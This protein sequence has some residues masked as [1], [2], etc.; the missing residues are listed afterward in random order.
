MGLNIASIEYLRL[1]H[2]V[3]SDN[4]GKKE[5]EKLLDKVLSSGS[6]G[7]K[8]LGGHYPL[9]VESSYLAIEVAS[10]KNAYV[11]FHAGSKE[12]GSNLNGALEAIKPFK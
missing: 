4:L 3:S 12:N 2:T 1:G 9:S 5:L 8:L 6:L 10:K 11:A 7:I